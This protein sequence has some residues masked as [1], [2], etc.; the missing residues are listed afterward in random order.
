MRDVAAIDAWLPQTQCTRCGYDDCR[1]Y[2]EAIAGND[3]AIDRCPPGGQATL[4]GLAALLSVDA[5]ATIAPDLERF[6]GYRL[7]RIVEEECIGCTKCIAACPVD[8]IIGSGKMMHTVVDSLCTGCELCIPPCPVDCIRLEQPEHSTP[9]SPHWPSFPS[10]APD[11]FRW[12]R[13]RRRE[14]ESDRQAPTDEGGLSKPRGDTDTI[15]N[16]ILE[17]VRRARGRRKPWITQVNENWT[18]K[19]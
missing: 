19:P 12:A 4:R 1:A 17:A 3:E 11:R 10:A 18:T 7:A 6:D 13:Q 15:D 9:R 5:P 16:E 8:A 14:R 2:A